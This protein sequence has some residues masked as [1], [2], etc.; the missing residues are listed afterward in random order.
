M[1]RHF[2][3]HFDIV[4]DGFANM[5]NAFSRRPE[6]S[7]FQAGCVSPVRHLYLEIRIG[8][9]FMRRRDFMAAAMGIPALSAVDLHAQDLS[10]RQAANHWEL[11]TS[12]IGQT[13]SWQQ[14]TGLRLNSLKN[15]LTGYEWAN[16]GSCGFAFA[17]ANHE[18][19]G[20]GP[21]S[22]FQFQGRESPDTRI[23]RILLFK[24]GPRG[25][26]NAGER[27]VMVL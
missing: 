16:Q 27:V 21:D 2:Y 4:V 10:D 19:N 15:K 5:S 1:S 6:R 26:S 11:G 13:V 9:A 17:S 22:G 14:A 20:L 8:G 25:P 3:G 7:L 18:I 12:L 23:R 24:K